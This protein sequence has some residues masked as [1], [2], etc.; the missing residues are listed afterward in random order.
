MGICYYFRHGVRAEFI[1]AIWGM[2]SLYGERRG[3]VPVISATSTLALDGRRGRFIEQQLVTALRIMQDGDIPAARMTGSWA[4]GRPDRQGRAVAWWFP[5]RCP[6][7]D[8]GG[9]DRLAATAHGTRI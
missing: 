5:A 9:L 4:G 6:R 2:E 8:Q 7:A 3:D 1:T